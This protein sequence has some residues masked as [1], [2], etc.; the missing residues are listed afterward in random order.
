MNLGKTTFKDFFDKLTIT[1]NSMTALGVKWETTRFALYKQR[2]EKAANRSYPRIIKSKD[3]DEERLFFEAASQCQQLVRSSQ[4]WA[5]IDCAV[6]ISKLEKVL[7]GRELPPLDNLD[8]EPRNTLL[9]L[10]TAAMLKRCGFEVQLTGQQADVIATRPGIP[11]LAVECK[12]PSSVKAIQRNLRRLRD[13]LT[14]R[15]HT[16][17]LVGMPVI[18]IDRI[19]ELAGSFVSTQST[20]M[21]EQIVVA[22]TKKIANDIL[23]VAWRQKITFAPM[24]PLGAVILVGT[25]YVGQESMPYTIEQMTAFGMGKDPQSE[26]LINSIAPAFRLK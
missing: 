18:G 6:L 26:S 10:M 17:E 5:D 22:K 24:A 19:S 8:D 3:F 14:K 12:R 1:F 21:V 2:W 4:I 20:D 9:E 16:G 25:V 13:Q 23:D 15:C 7:K 11:L